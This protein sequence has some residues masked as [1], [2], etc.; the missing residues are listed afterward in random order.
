MRPP[1]AKQHPGAGVARDGG[2]IDRTLPE[3]DS[4][5]GHG[6]A[7]NRINRTAFDEQTAVGGAFRLL[8]WPW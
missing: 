3:N 8:E 2:G 7:E 6:F 5:A 4:R 1:V